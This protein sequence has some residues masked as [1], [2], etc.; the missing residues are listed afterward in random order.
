VLHIVGERGLGAL[1]TTSL[2]EE[3]GVTPGALFRHFASRDEILD[4]SV[5]YAVVQIE[6]SFPDESSPPLER[7]LDLARRRVRLLV[8]DP[9]LA[10]LLRSEQAYLSLPRD[11][12]ERLRGLSVRSRRF[13]VD[14]IREGAREGSIRND[15]E[16]EDLAVLVMG[17][18]HALAGFPGVQ[19][20]ATRADRARRER[21]LSALE[22]MLR[23]AGSTGGPRRANGR[24][25]NRSRSTRR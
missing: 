11:G 17:T 22:R 1:T 15:I 3:I 14:A 21:V 4:A 23:P 10:W 24:K 9:G 16:P 5:R 2:A 18:V 6:E 25:T 19:G 13:V 8:S 20:R 12:V 7:V